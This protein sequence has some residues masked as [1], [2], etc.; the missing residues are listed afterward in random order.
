MT[1]PF[2][3]FSVRFGFGVVS[4]LLLLVLPVL[5]LLAPPDGIE[6]APLLQ[7]FGRFHPLSVHFPIG[8]LLLVP[9]FEILGRK[10]NVP[11]LLASV[12]FLLLVAICGAIMVAVLG[13][14]LARGGGYSGPLVQQHMW[15]GVLV[16][17]AAWLSWWQRSLANSP[18]PARLYAI[19]LVATVG[20]VSFTSYRGGQLSHG[21]NHLTQFMPTPLRGLL[22]LSGL[23]NDGVKPT[24]ENPA[25][26][27]GA[28]IQPLFEGHCITCHGQ[29]KH[30]ARLRLDSYAA[31]MRGGKHGPV[32]KPGDVK[33]SELFH[34]ITLPP[35]DDD[36]M[37]AENKRPLSVSDVEL[38][39][40]W[41]SSGASRTLAADAIAAVPA[42]SAS[43]TT[44]PELN[45]QE[46]D[47][48]A[49]TRE[50]AAFASIISQ[51]QLRLPNVVE[52]QSRTSANV[53][54]NASWLG[55]KFGDNDVVALAPVSDRIVAADFSGTA[56]T[57]RSARAIAAMKKLRQLRLAHTAI[58]DTTIQE[59]GSLDH[60]ES[61]S[62]FDTRVTASSLS[63][64][65]RLS[66]LQHVYAG[67]TKIPP[68]AA[69][70]TQI[71]DKLVF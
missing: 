32:I 49:V 38:I 69:I 22:G 42:N 47:P 65:A 3:N 45:F 53:V 64:F 26:F 46:I 57:D 30:K 8:V 67:E 35:S 25:T 24:E 56:I 44:V 27:Y 55:S 66:K 21:A 4:F 6:R 62:I 40:A 36:F 10:R 51:I 29:N 11:F 60:L 54:V 70:P 9:L 15:G 33:G 17:V 34:R 58:T 13:W 28:R 2:R 59:F 20:L 12:D 52:Y 41:I 37:P 50:R 31:V 39:G 43:Q 23:E 16:A 68:G 18:P 14:C 63:M 19:L 48:N 61:L 7:F 5:L 1:F 71:K